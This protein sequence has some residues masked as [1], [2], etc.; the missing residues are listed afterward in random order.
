MEYLDIVAKQQMTNIASVG[1]NSK[2][3]EAA[4]GFEAYFIEQMLQEMRKTIPKTE[5]SGFGNEIYESIIDQALA[6]K[7]SENSG[8]G[9][10]R[11]I[12]DSFEARNNK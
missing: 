8:I 3:V 5:K 6:Q 9:L 4:Q 1:N 2:K 7:M 11:Q 12:L 10:A